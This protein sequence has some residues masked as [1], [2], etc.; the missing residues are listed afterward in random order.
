META[1]ADGEWRRRMETANAEGEC[2]GRMQ[3]AN[4]DAGRFLGDCKRAG[5]H[6]AKADASQR[7]PLAP[8]R[9]HVCGPS[10]VARHHGH[11]H[12]HVR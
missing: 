1:N 2:R 3:R 7:G 4:A 10:Q 11:V 6:G 5:A 8:E 12:G 9:G